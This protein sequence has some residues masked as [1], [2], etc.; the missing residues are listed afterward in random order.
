MARSTRARVIAATLVV[1]SHLAVLDL[2]LGRVGTDLIEVPDRGFS[3]WVRLADR[4]RLRQLPPR[5]PDPR[6][7]RP[8]TVVPV[9]KVVPARPAMSVERPTNTAQLRRVEPRALDLH[10]PAELLAAPEAGR[11]DEPGWVFDR[12]LARQL[13]TA[14]TASAHRQ[15]LAS[16]RRARAGATSEEYERSAA[17]GEKLKTDAGCFEL[18]EDPDNGGTRWWAEACTDTR[19][20]PWEQSPWEQTALPDYPESP[21]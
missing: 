17:L 2:L 7:I 3:L 5:V 6:E 10:V 9:V 1:L 16:R 20:S 15:L 13:D 8:T 14:R 11:V 21:Q 4:P 12:K 18:R 19:Q